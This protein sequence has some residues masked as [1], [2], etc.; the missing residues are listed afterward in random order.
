M[1]YSLRKLRLLV[2]DPNGELA[3]NLATAKLFCA[4]EDDGESE[5]LGS[6]M[7]PEVHYANFW[8]VVRGQV[9]ALAVMR[10]EH[11]ALRLSWSTQVTVITPNT[12]ERQGFAHFTSGGMA[13]IP[14]VGSWFTKFSQRRVRESLVVRDG[15]VVFR[16]LSFQWGLG[17]H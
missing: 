7:G 13:A 6:L 5:E 15:R 10:K 8:G 1:S 16:D 17:V 14:L 12:F 4:A 3:T 11:S 2:D 9:A